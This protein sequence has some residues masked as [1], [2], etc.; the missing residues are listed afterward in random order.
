[1]SL[2][3]KHFYDFENFRI[4]PDERVLFCEGKPLPLT[5]KAFQMLLI[6]VQNRGHVVDKEKLM[7]EIW[8]D[9]CVE[10]GS[11]SVNAR[12]LRMALNDDAS[13]PKFIET[14]PRRGYRFIADVKENVDGERSLKPDD[15]GTAPATPALRQKLYVPL[16][17]A[18][19]L[20]AFIPARRAA[21]VNPLLVLR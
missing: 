3:T 6:L 5:P 21:K 14:I 19:L 12:R 10:E 9:S 11:L 8:A 13:R 18:G 16:I 15:R 1:M 7:D 2:G 4:D 20:A 17:A